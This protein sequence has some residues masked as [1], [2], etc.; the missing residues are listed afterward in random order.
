MAKKIKEKTTVS[1]VEKHSIDKTHPLFL[2]IDDYAF[3]SKNLY[4]YSNYLI[5]QTFIITSKMKN[6]QEITLEQCEFMDW[7]NCKVGE[8][9]VKKQ[10]NLLKRQLNGKDLNKIFEPLLCFNE[11]R[12]WIRYDFLE[13]L[14]SNGPDYKALMGQVAQQTLRLLDKNW[15]GFLKVL[16][17]GKTNPNKYLGMP[18]LPKYKHKVKGRFNVVFTNQNCKIK[19][20]FVVFPTC[21]NQYLLKTKTANKLQ[22]V[23]IKPLGNQYVIEIVCEKPIQELISVEPTRIAAIDL[24][25]N[26]FVTMTNNIGSEPVV[27]NGKTIKS[28][29]QFYNKQTSFYKSILKAETGRDWSKQL[30][31]LTTDRNNKVED[32]MHK[33]SKW[34]VKYC[35]ENQIDTLVVGNNKNWKQELNIGKRNNQNFV[36][37]PY[38]TLL[39]QLEYK[40]I[41]AGIKLIINEESYTSKASFIDGDEIPIY[42]KENPEKHKFSGRRIQRGMYKTKNEILINADVNGSYNILRKAFPK[43]FAEGIEG[44][45]LH[46]R[47]NQILLK[48]N[49]C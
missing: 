29:N 48:N 3:K 8:F 13:F 40:T 18:K 45:G 15:V 25:L 38:K 49:I 32:F 6:N 23:R 19:D 21:F 31:K 10:E 11:E 35:I 37:I 9:N 30:Q 44:V 46:P 26:N 16:K 7:L 27:I 22:Q 36:Q 43:A 14:T 34:I 28:I 5:R 17:I 2:L 41:D 4:N 12:K 42:S 39:N 20:G 47:R 33:S 1:R 24:G